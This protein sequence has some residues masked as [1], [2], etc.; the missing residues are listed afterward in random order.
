MPFGLQNTIKVPSNP[1]P[2]DAVY[3]AAAQ[4]TMHGEVALMSDP[5]I[6]ASSGST[7]GES[8]QGQSD[9]FAW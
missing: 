1:L 3:S 8:T 7:W 4:V 9:A 2:Q 6:L 5:A